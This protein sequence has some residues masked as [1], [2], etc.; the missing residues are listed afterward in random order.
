MDEDTVFPRLTISL[1]LAN[2]YMQN[3]PELEINSQ[4]RLT[5]NPTGGRKLEKEL[6]I[7]LDQINKM[8]PE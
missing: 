7:A 3:R 2:S 6:N 8:S 4:I 5:R 1:I